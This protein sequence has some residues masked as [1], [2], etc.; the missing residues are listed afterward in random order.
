MIFRIHIYIHAKFDNNRSGSFG[1]YLS[2][3]NRHRKTDRRTDRG[4]DKQTDAG[5]LFFRTLRVTTRQENR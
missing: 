4:T 2:N 5:D 3:K 1:D